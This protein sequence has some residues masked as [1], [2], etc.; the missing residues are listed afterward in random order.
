MEIHLNSVG[1]DGS[2]SG[3]NSVRS[4]GPFCRLAAIVL[5]NLFNGGLPF[6]LMDCGVKF[7]GAVYVIPII[8]FRVIL[9]GL[10]LQMIE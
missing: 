4:V 6:F 2:I 7:I 3:C 9:H 10:A 1:E 8:I 5:H